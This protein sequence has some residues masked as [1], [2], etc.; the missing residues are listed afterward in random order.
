[1]FYS[2]LFNKIKIKIILSHLKT[3]QDLLGTFN[4]L[5]V[6]DEFL[7][8]YLDNILKQTETSDS[9]FLC[10][11]LGGLISILYDLQ[12]KQRQICIDE[13]H[14]FSNTKNQK[15]FKQTFVTG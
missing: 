11:S 10:A 5:S 15:L 12:V 13:L 8:H 6:Q 9:R 3:L 4:D 14:I 7:Q 2:S 1:Y